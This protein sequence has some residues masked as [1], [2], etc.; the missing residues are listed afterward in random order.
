[1]SPQLI[2]ETRSQLISRLPTH[3]LLI[4][5]HGQAVREGSARCH[6]SLLADT[7]KVSVGNMEWC[8]CLKVF[9]IFE[10]YF[11]M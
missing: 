8:L 10:V 5:W 11:L 9:I 4:W 7:T 6:C 2:C 1:M 3:V